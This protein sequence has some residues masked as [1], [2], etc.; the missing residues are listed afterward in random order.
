MSLPAHRRSAPSDPVSLASPDFT[1]DRTGGYIG[2]LD[3]RRLHLGGVTYEM[4]VIPTYV[5][6]GHDGATDAGLVAVVK[7]G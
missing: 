4:C 2:V 3:L 7:L 6:Y 1:K 5:R